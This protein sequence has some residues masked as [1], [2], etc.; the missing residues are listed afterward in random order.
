[1]AEIYIGGEIF[2]INIPQ[3]L[4][5]NEIERA[6]R[7]MRSWRTSKIYRHRTLKLEVIYR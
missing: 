1:M 3:R 5:N 6:K 7:K 2:R 4:I